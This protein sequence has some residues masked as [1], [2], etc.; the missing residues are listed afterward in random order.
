MFYSAIGLIAVLILLIENGDIL[1]ARKDALEKPAWKV[2]KKFLFAVLAYYV[3]D[4]LWGILESGHMPGLLF[5]DT[6]AYFIAMAAGLLFLTQFTAAYSEEET[7]FGKSLVYAGW[8]V[9]GGISFLALLN[10]TTPLLFTV[11]ESGVYSPFPLRHVI[12]A[13]QVLLLLLISGY[14]YS[15]LRVHAKGK[16]RALTWFGLIMAS[17]VFAQIWFPYVPLY[18]TAYMLGTCLLH[19]FVINDEKEEYRQDAADVQKVTEV[20]DTFASLLNNMPAMAF[21][22]DA[23]TGAYLACNQAF[24]D[25]AHKE[26]PADA[27]GLTDAQLFDAETAKHF[28]EEDRVALSMDEPYIFYEEANDAVGNRHQLQTTKQKYYNA[29]GRL[30]VLGM[31]QDVTKTIRI[32]RENAATKEAYENARNAGIMYNHMAQSMARGYMVLYRV[33]LDTEEYVKYRNDKESGTLVEMDRGW[34]FFEECRLIAEK[35]VHPDDRAEVI[36]ALKRKTLVAALEQS[37]TFAITYRYLSEDESKDVTM[38]IS[39]MEE[40][41]RYIIMGI[42]DVDDAMKRRREMLRAQEERLAYARLNALTGDYLCVYIIEPD[43]NRYHEFSSSQNFTFFPQAKEGNDFFNA[44]RDVARKFTHPEDLNRFLSLFTREN[45][46]D[47]IDRRGIFTLSYRLMLDNKPLYVQMKAAMLKEDEGPRL[48]VGLNDIDTQVQQ[49]EE[50]VKRM[51][52]AQLNANID[53]LTGVQN[54]HAFLEAEERLNLQ[55][56]EN[57][58]MEFSISLLDVN[59]LKK[60]NDTEGHNAGDQFLR[61]ACKIICDTF[62]HSPVFRIGGDE[63]A[64]ISQGSD[65]ANID[66]LVREMGRH[67]EQ[68]MQSNGIV[69]ACGMSKRG[70]GEKVAQVFERADQRMYENKGDLKARRKT[71]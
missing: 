3:T 10:I 4:I 1:L 7:E 17:F 29:D 39:R 65:Y 51:A 23:E 41:D 9:G 43:T 55:I 50:Y 24:A 69:I 60:V 15:R 37:K 45:I 59:D 61:K 31:C 56:E 21:S 44:V 57:R 58:D 48:I 11:D 5:V 66:E 25:Y 71:V 2:Y 33:N 42:T 53:A 16:Y 12:L 63:F 35:S 8:S 6:T 32:Q 34:H 64:V 38:R 28:M 26:H 14:S 47:E 70:S 49:E 46:M 18:S 62:K 13:A 20:R 68:A 67:N 54:R 19:T 27:I 36:K 22:K 30:C 52:K 40:D